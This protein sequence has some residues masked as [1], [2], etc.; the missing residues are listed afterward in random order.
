MDAHRG[1]EVDHRARFLASM[2]AV[3]RHA[4]PHHVEVDMRIANRRSGVRAVHDAGVDTHLAQCGNRLREALHLDAEVERSLA[5][6]RREVRERA[7]QIERTMEAHL[8]HEIDHI[9]IAYADAVHT[10]VHRQV[11]RCANAVLVSLLGVGNGKLRRVD[12]R[13]DLV[14]E[15]QGRRRRGRLGQK[16]D[17]RPHHALAQLDALVY[18]SDSQVVRA[19]LQR[20]LRNTHSTVAVRVGLHHGEKARARLD[21]RSRDTDVVADGRKIDFHP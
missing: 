2:Q 17:W 21:E 7:H 9:V 8:P 4:P 6:R 16:H 1:L 14:G 13:H 15:Q 19:R 10:R 12:G 3:E 5:V 11:E 20:G 18:R